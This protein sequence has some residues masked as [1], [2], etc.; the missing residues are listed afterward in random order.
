MVA[1]TA[2]NIRQLQ[3]KVCSRTEWYF[4]SYHMTDDRSPLLLSV[5][6]IIQLAA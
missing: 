6:K 3:I 2:Q 5:V 4:F 1:F